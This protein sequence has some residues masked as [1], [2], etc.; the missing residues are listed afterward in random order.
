LL[1]Y[2]EISFGNRYKCKTIEVSSS[3]KLIPD[4]IIINSAMNGW[5]VL[6]SFQAMANPPSAS[7]QP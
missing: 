6:R 5:L 3:R 2:P 7:I 1:R 4:I